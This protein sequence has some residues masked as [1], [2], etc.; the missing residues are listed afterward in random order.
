[1]FYINVGDITIPSEFIITK[2]CY[3][4]MVTN[5]HYVVEVDCIDYAYVKI[6]RYNGEDVITEKRV[7]SIHFFLDHSSSFKAFSLE[8]FNNIK[9]FL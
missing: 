1:M 4:Y 3:G 8:K 6:V 7:I 2:N 5:A 9:A